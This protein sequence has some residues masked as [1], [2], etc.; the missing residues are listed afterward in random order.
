[1][2]A[3]RPSAVPG[4][5]HQP[6]GDPRDRSIGHL[7]GDIS[8]D[9]SMLVRQEVELAKAEVR[10]DA[11]A[12]GKAGGMFGGAGFAGYMTILFLS[13]AAWWGLANAIDQGWA[14]LVVAVIWAVIGGGLYVVARKQ[15][16]AYKGL[17]RTKQT[18]SDVPGAFKVDPRR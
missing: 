11:K 8:R 3:T 7:L 2:T 12:A 17:Q 1:M 4:T 6:D 15:M 13:F 14:A 10:E 5:V 18:L 16:R 9:V